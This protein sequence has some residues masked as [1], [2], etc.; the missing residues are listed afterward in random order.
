MEKKV[1]ELCTVTRKH[2]GDGV[3]IQKVAPDAKFVHC[4]ITAMFKAP[5][6]CQPF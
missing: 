2:I 5:F 4:N 1:S 3:Q 6:N